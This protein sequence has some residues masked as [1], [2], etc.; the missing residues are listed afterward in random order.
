MKSGLRRVQKTVRGKRGTVRRSYWMRQ[1]A[2]ARPVTSGRRAVKVGAAVG[3]VFGGALGALAGAGAGAAVR[4]R[5]LTASIR[6]ADPW[7]YVGSGTPRAHGMM[8]N[9]LRARP[10]MMAGHYGGGM[11]RGGG[12]GAV[13]GAA[14]GAAIGAAAGYAVHRVAS[15]VKHRFGR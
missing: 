11:A 8:A 4:H 6:Q 15:A 10:Q 1:E 9:L 5:Q 13:V 7:S 14:G 2:A 3:A 12:A